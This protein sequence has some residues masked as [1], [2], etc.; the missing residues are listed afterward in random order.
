MI[1]FPRFTNFLI[2]DTECSCGCAQVNDTLPKN[3]CAS[4]KQYAETWPDALTDKRPTGP[5]HTSVSPV[6]MIIGAVIS[7]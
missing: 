7:S 3:V 6:E 5:A 1:T 4:W 2:C